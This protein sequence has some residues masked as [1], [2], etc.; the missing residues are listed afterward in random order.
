MLS[1]GRGVLWWRPSLSLGGLSRSSPDGAARARSA[2]SCSAAGRI[3]GR[4]PCPDPSFLMP[5]AVDGRRRRCPAFTP[6]IRRATKDHRPLRARGQPRR[7]RTCPDHATANG[8]PDSHLRGP[9]ARPVHRPS[10]TAAA[11]AALPRLA[12]RTTLASPPAGTPRSP[13]QRAPKSRETSSAVCGRPNGPAPT[14]QR[15]DAWNPRGR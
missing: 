8:R 9:A 11:P 3:P 14:P 12:R 13:R 5:L 10:M 4:A 2:D 1:S 6:V 7:R 15:S